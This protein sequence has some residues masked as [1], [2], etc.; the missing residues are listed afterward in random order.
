M[1]NLINLPQHEHTWI[2]EVNDYFIKQFGSG[3]LTDAIKK[4]GKGPAIY[5]FQLFDVACLTALNKKENHTVFVE[6]GTAEYDT[7]IT[8]LS[9]Q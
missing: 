7:W 5:D 9:L 4:K 2:Y 6:V 1:G 8:P 3:I